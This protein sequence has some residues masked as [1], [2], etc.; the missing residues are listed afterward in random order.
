M[1]IPRGLHPEVSSQGFLW[2]VNHFRAARDAGG[3]FVLVWQ[4]EDRQSGIRSL[5]VQRLDRMGT[6][7][8]EVITLTKAGMGAAPFSV[9][10]A[11]NEGGAFVA[12]WSGE[13]DEEGHVLAWQQF[14]H[15]DEPIGPAQVLPTYGP[16]TASNPHVGCDPLG[17]CLIAWEEDTANGDPKELVAATLSL[18]KGAA[19][20]PFVVSETAADDGGL[21]ECEPARLENTR[22]AGIATR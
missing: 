8:G 18:E 20:I 4:E 6:A 17:R 5:Q 7:S 14:S 12:V 21:L 15:L 9:S 13:V 3:S 2:H 22:S 10:V 16:G 1:Q 11:C 19:G